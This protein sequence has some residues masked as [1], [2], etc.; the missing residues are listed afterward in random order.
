[1]LFQMQENN[2]ISNLYNIKVVN[3]KR[4]D[5]PIQI[6]LLSHKG[7]ILIPAGDMIVKGGS[8]SEGVFVVY[9]NRDEVE[10][11]IPIQLG[12]FNGDK[13]IEKIR[14]TFVGPN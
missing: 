8:S 12:V 1:M 3:K 11:K 13:L 14:L 5:F 9:L 7:R 2:E 6:K 10:G 4:I